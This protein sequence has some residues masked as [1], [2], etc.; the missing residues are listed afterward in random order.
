MNQK[1]K[2]A[3]WFDSIQFDMNISTRDSK[4]E[5]E[6]LLKDNFER[7]IIPGPLRK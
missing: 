1:R 4:N 7:E 6:T 2:E 3:I 5:K